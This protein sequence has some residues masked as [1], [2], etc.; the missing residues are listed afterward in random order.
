MHTR[1][2][3]SELYHELNHSTKFHTIDRYNRDPAMSSFKR[4][5]RWSISSAGGEKNSSSDKSTTDD[6]RS[7]DSFKTMTPEQTCG[8]CEHKDRL[9]LRNKPWD[10][11]SAIT[12]DTSEGDFQTEV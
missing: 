2:R 1:K 9:E 10:T 11:S 3:H 12:P 6:Q 5:K 8:S 7:W 4:E